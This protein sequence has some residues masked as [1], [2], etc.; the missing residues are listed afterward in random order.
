MIVTNQVVCRM[1]NGW[2]NKEEKYF[3]GTL[4]VYRG[5]CY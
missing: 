4:V 5:K 1:N 2:D 3:Q